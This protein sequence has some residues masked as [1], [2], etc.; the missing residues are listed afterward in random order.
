MNFFDFFRR[1]SDV[2]GK[3][4]SST[5][6]FQGREVVVI[7][8]SHRRSLT[9]HMKPNQP[10]RVTT[11][12]RVTDTEILNFLTKKAKWIE[13]HADRFEKI[14][15]P[16]VHKA[17]P[18]EKWLLKGRELILKEAL[19]LL[20]NPFVVCAEDSITVYYPESQWATREQSRSLVL[21]LIETSIRQEAESTLRN[22]VQHYATQMQLFP[23]KI[24]LM[25]ARTRWGSCSSRGNLN[26]NWRL[27]G[28]PLEVIDSI[29]VHELAHLKHMNHSAEFWSLV[30][31]FN[32]KHE[33][34]DRW[35]RDY[36]HRL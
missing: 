32:P 8:R 6:Q 27:I 4:K 18:G 10:I 22:R 19:T 30:A 33:D 11:A 29:V 14:P 28:A 35:L 21:P 31:Q 24:R 7:R 36:Q 15:A 5:L 20:K 25:Q 17:E 16:M 1:P 9:I 23:K 26:F 3:S 2:S 13:K 12:L 34:S